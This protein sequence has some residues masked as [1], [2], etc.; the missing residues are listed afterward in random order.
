MGDPNGFRYLGGFIDD[1][2]G[3]VFVQPMRTKGVFALVLS[4]FGKWFR[5]HAL[6]VRRFLR[7][8]DDDLFL[9]QLRTDRG[10][11]MT[12][13]WGF[14]RTL[15]DATASCLF[16][17]RW[18]GSAGVPQSATP[19]LSDSGALFVRRLIVLG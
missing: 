15:F 17:S 13:T 7:L 12:C 16:N 9:G 19:V 18:F 11:E 14:H 6:T 10:G 4:E 1:A 2:S 3:A 8:S 5:R